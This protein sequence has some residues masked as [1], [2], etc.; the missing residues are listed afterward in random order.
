[1]IVEGLSASAAFCG[2]NEG[3]RVKPL[4]EMKMILVRTTFQVKFGHMDAMLTTAKNLVDYGRALASETRVLTDA[5]GP[6]FTL[7][8]ESKAESIGAYM[9]ALRAG[10]SDPQFAEIMANTMEHVESGRREFFNIEW[11]A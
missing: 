11:E 8:I 7:V 4:K 5:S 6:M 10:F 1:V 2:R 3:A 9:E